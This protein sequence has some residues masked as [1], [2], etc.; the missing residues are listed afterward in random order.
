MK[1]G[2]RHEDRSGQAAAASM[3]E[4]IVTIDFMARDVF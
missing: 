1:C 4:Y 2:P 3:I